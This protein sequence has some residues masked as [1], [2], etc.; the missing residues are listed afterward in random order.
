MY[1]KIGPWIKQEQTTVIKINTYARDSWV[2]WLPA[3]EGL[4]FEG[5][6][7]IRKIWDTN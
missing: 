3:K 1:V 5:V 4:K 7:T 6:K 2:Q